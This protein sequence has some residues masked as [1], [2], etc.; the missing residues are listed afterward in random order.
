MKELDPLWYRDAII[1][2]THVKAFFDSNGDG[3]GDL[4]GLTERLDYVQSLGV[5]ALWLLPFY[6]SPLRDDGYDIADYT[7]I[8]PAYGDM[9][10]FKRLVREAQ[11]RDIRIILELVIN[12][13]SDAHPWFQ[14]ARRSKP[15]TVRRNYY[16]WSDTDQK[17]RDA[18]IIFLDTEKSNWAWDPI[19]QAYYWHRFYS[20][21]PDLNFDNPRVLEEILGVMRF[22]LDQGADGLRLDAVPYLV[23]REGTSCENLPETHAIIKRI[24]AALDGRYDAKMLLAEANQWPEDVLPYFGDG[25]ECHMAFHFPLMPRIYMAVAQEDRLPITDILS[26]TP[27]IPSTCQWAIFLRNHDELTLEMVTNR[28]RDYLWN[29][30]AADNRMRLNLGIRRRLAPLMEGDRRKIELLNSL[31][32]SLPGTPIIYYGDEI[33]MGDNI[34]L[35]DRDGVRT[36]MQWSSDRN[37]GFSKADPARLFLPPIMDPVYGYGAINVEAQARNPYSL[38]NWMKRLISVRQARRVFGRGAMSVLH[39]ANRR[40]LAYL[41]EYDGD[42]VLCVANLSRWPQ[43]VELDLAAYRGRIPV[44]LMGRIPFPRV[45]DLPYMLTL[46]G[47]GF[48]WFHLASEVDLPDWQ[49][50]APEPVPDVP[51]LVLPRGWDSLLAG[52]PRRQLETEVLGTY[53]SAQRWFAGKGSR[54]SAVELTACTVLHAAESAWLVAIVQASLRSG[55]QHR[56]FLPM[57]MHW[58]RS[59]DDPTLLTAAP[60]TIARIRRGANLGAIYDAFADES[61]VLYLVESIRAQTRIDLG[62]TGTIACVSTQAMKDFALPEQLATRRLRVEQSN[63]SVLIGEHMVLKCYRRLHEGTQPEIEIGAFLTDVAHFGNA[64]KLLGYMELQSGTNNTALVVLQQFIQNHGD[65][66]TYTLSYLERFYDEARV[67]PANE[68]EQQEDRHLYAIRLATI[69]GTRTAELHHAFAMTTGDPAFDPEPVTTEDLRHWHERVTEQ[70]E[71]SL[72]MLAEHLNI[73]PDEIREET[74]RLLNYR[75][76]I[77]AIL[78]SLVPVDLRAQK[79]RTH[80]DYHLAQVLVEKDDFFIIDFEGEPARPLAER[81]AKHLPLR[82]VAGM[83]RSFDYA[84]WASLLHATA[85]NPREV[86]VLLGPA[87][88]WRDRS[89]AAFLDGYRSAIVGCPSFPDNDEHAAM[90]LDLFVLEKAFYEI[91]YEAANRPTWLR[92]PLQG[93]LAILER[94]DQG[95]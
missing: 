54:I 53:L 77:R 16:V 60:Y 18:R 75:S 69:L 32:M 8:N 22:W 76:R 89:I 88:R 17:Y 59:S 21:Q 25:D 72:G 11:R 43:P 20:H 34:Y 58:E 15:G 50:T 65:G 66:W 47:Y 45:G 63:T 67:L 74:H 92:I 10:D 2:Q 29:H 64:P 61:L 81:R 26:Q 87:M 51:T 42:L 35:G 28:E 71:R 91:A 12:H 40:V 30:Y 31:L 14:R 4:R 41:R 82:D 3:I 44:E 49:S 78:A 5:S 33:G 73:V 90:L 6:P 79:T 62:A 37:G 48:Y 80:G 39:P 70:V 23:E 57:A 27:D 84:A 9:R 94:H 36:P 46:P 55:E 1:Y 19:A 7:S 83:V 24:R 56:Y 93:V 85:E 95:P 68:I 52:Q 86:D 38:L 13:T